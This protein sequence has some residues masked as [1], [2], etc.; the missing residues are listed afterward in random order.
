MQAAKNPSDGKRS[1]ILLI[2]DDKDV[3]PQRK[4]NLRKAGYGV[5]L[6]VETEDAY[7]WMCGGYIHADIVMIDLMGK[8]TDEALSIGR[9]V[10]K[11]AKY[12]GHTP[13]VVMAEKYSKDVEGT[14]VNIEGNDW[15]HYL[16][17]DPK[18]LQNLLA[19]LK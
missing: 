18:Q 6:A 1:T 16:G 12:N 17:E 5:L 15:I 19:Y 4:R 10:R 11:H 7:A 13:L 3:Y 9:E 14:D 8:T 2:A